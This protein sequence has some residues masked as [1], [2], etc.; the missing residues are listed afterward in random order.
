MWLEL[1]NYS[2]PERNLLYSIMYNNKKENGKAM[3]KT[4][5]KK[6]KMYL[7]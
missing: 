2:N 6:Y 3:R 1:I 4:T 7:L 5:S